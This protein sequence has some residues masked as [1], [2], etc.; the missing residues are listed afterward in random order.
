M[1]ECVWVNGTHMPSD[2]AEVTTAFEDSVVVSGES[3]VMPDDPSLGWC[4]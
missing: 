1:A 3:W 4:K 2:D